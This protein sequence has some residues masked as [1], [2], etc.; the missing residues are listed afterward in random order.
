MKIHQTIPGC[1]LAVVSFTLLSGCS[2]PVATSVPGSL[3]AS[4]PP[5]VQGELPV[6]KP[7]TVCNH[8]FS[9]AQL[10]LNPLYTEIETNSIVTGATSAELMASLSRSVPNRGIGST[11]WNINWVFDTQRG[12]R[13][14]DLKNVQTNVQIDYHLPLWPGRLT[15]ANRTLID[16][17]NSYSDSLRVH[18]CQH[19]KASIDAALEVKAALQQLPLQGSCSELQVE[20]D[21]LARSII[22]KYK[23]IE[24]GFTAPRVT[25]FLQR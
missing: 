4:V 20:A 13:G 7:G 15:A 11:R 3:P 24:A 5:S 9:T 8:N 21:A 10:S 25:D 23:E 19:G 12:I 16:Q 22:G 1:L 6:A 17:W 2:A 14:C 18:H